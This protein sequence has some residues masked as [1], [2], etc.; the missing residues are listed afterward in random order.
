MIAQFNRG[1]TLTLALLAVVFTYIAFPDIARSKD[2]ALPV[3][4]EPSHH[5]RFDNGK[6]RVY[7][8]RVPAGYWTEF[9]EHTQDNFFVFIIPTTQDYEFSDGRKGTREVKAGDVGFAST[10]TGP[11][12]HRV[13]PRSEPL[14]VVDIEILKNAKLGSDRAA[15]RSESFKVVLENPRGRAYDLILKPGQ[16]TSLFTRAPNTGIF[17]VSGGRVSETPEGK[18]PRLWDSEPGDFRWNELPE[19]LTLTNASPQEEH[20]VE[21]ELF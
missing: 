20:F 11:Y 10:A 6:V 13:T 21:I 1:I 4:N 3:S 15:K 16:S 14:H 2:P 8:V 9:H 19:R 12:I 7:D 17:V 5:I 18:A